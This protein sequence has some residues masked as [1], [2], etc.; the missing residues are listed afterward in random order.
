[1]LLPFTPNGSDGEHWDMHL[2][3]YYRLADS[4]VS[5]IANLRIYL[6]KLDIHYKHRLKTTCLVVKLGSH[7]TSTLQTLG[8]LRGLHR[9]TVEWAGSHIR[10]HDCPTMKRQILD[11][12]TEELEYVKRS[13]DIG[14]VIVG[15]KC[16]K[17]S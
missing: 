8:R 4:R 14:V 1:M 17:E 16:Y 10:E 5:A 13:P 2:A 15:Y 11:M 7:L 6:G 3:V 12:A 9:V